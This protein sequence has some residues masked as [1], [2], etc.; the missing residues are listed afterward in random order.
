MA[1]SA[2][3]PSLKSP[4]SL[5]LIAALLFNGYRCCRADA[6]S[7][8]DKACAK[9][10]AELPKGFSLPK[11]DQI[12][13]NPLA[14][15]INR[16]IQ[17]QIRALLLQKGGELDRL[18][19]AVVIIERDKDGQH[20]SATNGTCSQFFID[21][22]LLPENV[23]CV[24]GKETKVKDEHQQKECSENGTKCT[25]LP[26]NC[27][28]PMGRVDALSYV[29]H[30]TIKLWARVDAL[31]DSHCMWKAI[32]DGVRVLKSVSTGN[33][34]EL[35][36]CWASNVWVCCEPLQLA[37]LFSVCAVVLVVSVI[38]MV[39][40]LCRKRKQPTGRH[41]KKKEDKEEATEEDAVQLSTSIAAQYGVEVP[42]SVLSKT[43]DDDEEMQT[44]NTIVPQ[45][46]IPGSLEAP[47]MNADIPAGGRVTV[48]EPLHQL[49][50]PKNAEEDIPKSLLSNGHHDED[51]DESSLYKITP[52]QGTIE[53]P[54]KQ[55]PIAANDPIY[56][57]LGDLD[58][59]IFV[60]LSK[61]LPPKTQAAANDPIYQT[62][63]DLDKD[64]FV[65]PSKP[66][67]PKTQ[68]A[69][70]DP[71]YQT[72]GDLDKDIF[73]KPSK[74]LPPKT[75]AAA[76]DPIYQ[77]LGDLDKDIFIKQPMTQ[78]PPKTQAAANDPI[79][80]T[81]GDLDKDIFIK[82]PMTQQPPKTQAAANDPIYQTLGNLDKDIFIKQPMTQPPP[83]TQAAANDPIYQTLGNLDK[84]IF[85]KQPMTQPPKKTQ[86]AASDPIYQTLGNLDK[87]IFIKQPMTQPP[88]KPQAAASDPI[89]QTL[90]NLDKDIFIKQPM[91][92]PPK[93]AQTPA[94]KKS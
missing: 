76:N 35:E 92:Q 40:C 2:R 85:I 22:L 74:P 58:K 70:N 61:P 69:A 56:Q 33:S 71:I 80:Q 43:E 45:K 44:P 53:A 14:L 94:A 57:T 27:N 54:K 21:H 75:Q 24:F 46:P 41:T 3:L 47:P 10:G 37:V 6:F 65:K 7:L 51:E 86:A 19:F 9:K 88:P 78:P 72:L 73:V 49:A 55:D 13:M 42:D 93:K 1:T 81:L 16:T 79:Y 59:D 34:N 38:L 64:I 84:D 52:G 15:G 4:S 48:P 90:G 11:D 91:T 8:Q 20:A 25:S 26:V 66:L 36:K 77:T 63:G 87:D 50:V 68:A 32:I 83:K 67:P 28:F 23:N 12:L 5:L 31:N 60:K 39:A 30:F 62:L 18:H 82:Q 29:R 17:P 89:Y